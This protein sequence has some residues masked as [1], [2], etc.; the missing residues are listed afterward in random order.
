MPLLPTAVQREQ[1]SHT[2]AA[3]RCDTEGCPGP[4]PPRRKLWARIRAALTSQ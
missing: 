3:Y 4:E 1:G 2:A